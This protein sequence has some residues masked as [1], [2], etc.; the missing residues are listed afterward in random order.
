[1]TP[2]GETV[3]CPAAFHGQNLFWHAASALLLFGWWYHVTGARWPSFLVAAL[4]AVHPMHVESVAWAIERKDVLSGFFG[5][6][7]LWAYVWYLEKPTWLRYLLVPAAYV[8]SLL[9]KPM[10]LTLPCVLLL[11][12]YWPLRRLW[13]APGGERGDAALFCHGMQKRAA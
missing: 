12:D 8:P 3:L 6:L 9:S 1:H 13:P 7:T 10:L 11:L 2:D 4:F 5:V